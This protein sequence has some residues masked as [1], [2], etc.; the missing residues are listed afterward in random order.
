MEHA[1]VACCYV[2]GRRGRAVNTPQLVLPSRSSLPASPGPGRSTN[3]HLTPHERDRLLVAA[4]ADLARRRL[5]RGARIGATE[6]AALIVDEVHELAWDGHDLDEVVRRA[7]QILTAEQL[8]PGVPEMIGHLQVD[9]LFPAGTFLVDI[10][11]PVPLVPVDADTNQ[12]APRKLN[13]GLPRRQA[14]VEND[15]P[16]TVR[17][18]SHA[19]FAEVNPALRFD[20]DAVRGWRLDIPAGSS[21]PW[22]PG[23]TRTVTLVEW[24]R[25]DHEGAD[26]AGA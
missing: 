25:R 12:A 11:E 1:F 6:A 15:S 26:D 22:A 17:V 8:L 16:R 18:T 21:L 10:P 5:A 4:A 23:E 13:A 3:V 7:R 20:R 24:R 2:N 9:A 14:T 19:D